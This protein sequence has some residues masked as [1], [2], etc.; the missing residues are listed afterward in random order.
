VILINAHHIVQSFASISEAAFTLQR[1]L[2]DVL[3]YQ[4]IC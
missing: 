2:D 4:T 3:K 1:P